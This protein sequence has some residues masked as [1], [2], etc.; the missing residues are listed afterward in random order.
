MRALAEFIMRGRLQ[1][2]A[3]AVLGSIV[4]FLTASTVAM[5]TLRKGAFEG[6]VIVLISLMPALLPLILG[7]AGIIELIA[8]V[9]LLMTAYV[10]ALVLR[11]TISLPL[12]IVTATGVSALVAISVV[13][14]DSE[15]VSWVSDRLNTLYF[16]ESDGQFSLTV[17]SLSGTIGVI[18]LFNSVSGLL[19]GRWLQAMVFNPGGFGSEFRT[20]RLGA[21]IAIASFVIS[22][23]L[24]VQS[25]SYLLW[26]YIMACPLM[27]VALAVGHQMIARYQMGRPWLVFFYI[28]VIMFPVFAVVIGF[29]DTWVNFRERYQ[30][31]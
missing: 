26:A 27:L 18:L 11:A 15:L 19:L 9:L 2:G 25:G 7:S 21:A 22:A 3:M 30:P 13:S 6:T 5:V 12:A 17:A 1:A 16:P 28:V 8:S 10:P 4:P 23:I 14:V 31:K 29:L 24:Y 20:F